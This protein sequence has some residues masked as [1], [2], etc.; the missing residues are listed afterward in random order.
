MESEKKQQ[1]QKAS[2]LQADDI[3]DEMIPLEHNEKMAHKQVTDNQ[4]HTSCLRGRPKGKSC[5]FHG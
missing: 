5:L 1:T 4:T 2:Q 3:Q